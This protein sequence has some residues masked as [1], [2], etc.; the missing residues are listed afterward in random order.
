MK[1]YIRHSIIGL[2]RFLAFD[3]RIGMVFV[4]ECIVYNVIILELGFV[5]SEGGKNKYIENCEWNFF[6]PLSE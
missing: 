2:F 1:I 3:M 5:L 4:L 6:I